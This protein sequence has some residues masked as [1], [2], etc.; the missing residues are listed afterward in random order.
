M[1]YLVRL[2]GEWFQLRVQYSSQWWL[3]G[4][5]HRVRRSS[6]V[7]RRSVRARRSS[8]GSAPAC[9]IAGPSSNIFLLGIPGG[10]SH[11][12]YSRRW[13][14][15]TYGDWSFYWSRIH[16]RTI[17]SRFL[18]SGHNLESSQTWGFCMDFLNQQ[19]GAMVFYQVFLLSSLQ[20]KVAEL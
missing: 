16:E 14:M 4:V 17:S 19:E 8:V 20:C 12:V 18:L 2:S 11:W 5:A 13:G 1:N 3:C 15:S 7:R 9:C 10:F 6:R